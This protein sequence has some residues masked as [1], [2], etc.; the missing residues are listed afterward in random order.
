MNYT[1]LFKIKPGK[2]QELVEWFWYLQDNPETEETMKEE[3]LD[4]EKTFIFQLEGNW[5]CLYHMHSPTSKQKSEPRELNKQHKAKLKAC[6]E[7][8]NQDIIT[9]LDKILKI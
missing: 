7:P 3:N 6:L 2:T 8:I 5:Y 4:L 9:P 1:K